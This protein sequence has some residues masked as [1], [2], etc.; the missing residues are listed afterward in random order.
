MILGVIFAILIGWGIGTMIE[1]YRWVGLAKKGKYKEVDG[2]LFKVI[3]LKPKDP[4]GI[5]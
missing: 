4:G 1:R 5:R 3:K 2:E